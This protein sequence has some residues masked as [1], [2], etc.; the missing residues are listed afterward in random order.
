MNDDTK[1]LRRLIKADKAPRFVFAKQY[2]PYK[3]RWE[4]ETAL[5]K[6]TGRQK[7]TWRQI[8]SFTVIEKGLYE[9]KPETTK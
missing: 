2:N 4:P 5:N 8:S 6:K 9:D 7:R 1:F 3:D